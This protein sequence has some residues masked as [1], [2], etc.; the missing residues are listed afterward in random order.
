M[1]D[2]AIDTER[3]NQI[4]GRV[5]SGRIEGTDDFIAW[6]TSLFERSPDAIIEP[7]YCAAPSRRGAVYVGST[8]GTLAVARARFDALE[9]KAWQR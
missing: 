3:Q 9:P 1:R 7:M 6:L 5:R 4:L 2:L 8:F